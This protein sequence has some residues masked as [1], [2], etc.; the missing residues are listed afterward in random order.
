MGEIDLEGMD[1]L[2]VQLAAV[3]RRRIQDGTYPEGKRIPSSAELAE[4]FGLARPTVVKAV[5][6]LKDEGLVRGVTGRGTFVLAR[7]QDG[8]GS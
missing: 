3:L 4:E 1:P 6:L 8:A 2:Y 7:P 5:G